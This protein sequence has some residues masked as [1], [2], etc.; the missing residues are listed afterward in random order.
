MY[1]ALLEEPSFDICIVYYV[2]KVKKTKKNTIGIFVNFPWN[3]AYIRIVVDSCVFNLRC[4]AWICIAVLIRAL[5]KLL[6]VL[7]GP[8]GSTA[9]SH[10]CML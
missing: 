6:G 7:Y 5:Y 10:V 3:G 8:T 9:I 1:I 2:E 4:M